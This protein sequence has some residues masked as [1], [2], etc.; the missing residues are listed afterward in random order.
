[1]VLSRGG[2]RSTA[3][4]TGAESR[5]SILQAGLQKRPH[6]SGHVSRTRPLPSAAER[7]TRG[8]PAVSGPG[9]DWRREFD[10]ISLNGSLGSS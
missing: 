5:P 2:V 8:L 10:C 4:R 6:M 3:Q 9:E 1:M 7:G